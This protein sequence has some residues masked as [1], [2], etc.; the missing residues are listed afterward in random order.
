MQVS[1][2]VL[3]PAAAPTI[4]AAG[5]APAP[6]PSAITSGSG[7]IPIVPIIPQSA[8]MLAPGPAPA[9]A[10]VPAPLFAPA[11]AP[12]VAPIPITPPVCS[13]K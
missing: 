9:F 1:M 7:V 4:S 13:S 2:H 8:S 5:G 11:V 10:P 3:Q 6:A 12:V